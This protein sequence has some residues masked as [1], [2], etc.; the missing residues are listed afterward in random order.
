MNKFSKLYRVMVQAS[1]EYRPDTQSL[2]NMFV[3]TAN[4]KMPPISTYL[5]LTRGYGSEFLSR[6][7]MFASVAVNGSPADGYS[8]GQAIEA[9][10]EVALRTLSAGYGYEFGAMTREE[11]ATGNTSVFVFGIC[12]AFIYL[13]LCALYESLF[14]P[15]AVILSVPFGLAG[16]FL[17]ARLFGMENN[18]Y[19]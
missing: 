15:L 7:N 16:S 17:F 6:F 14:I 3:R 19:M 10:R 8:S 1:P 2:D 9:I 13:I 11:A 12:I 18:I 5:T 4:G